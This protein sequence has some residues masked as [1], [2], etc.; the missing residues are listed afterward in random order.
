MEE[1]EPVDW[2]SGHLV[3][4]E[5]KQGLRK[6]A[7]EEGDL[8]LVSFRRRVFSRR[9]YS[10]GHGKIIGG[11]EKEVFQTAPGAKGKS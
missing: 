4:W 10:G 3:S 8:Y 1:L 11:G 5:L 7:L 2:V 9:S 6:G